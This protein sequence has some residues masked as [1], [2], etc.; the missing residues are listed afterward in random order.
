MKHWLPGL[1]PQRI[2]VST[3]TKGWY[4][5]ADKS[6]Y[7]L[8][9]VSP[10]ATPETVR[11]AY[12]R[13]SE[14]Y[15]PFNVDGSFNSDLKIRQDAIK[16]AFF[17]LGAPEKRAKYDQDRIEKLGA[18]APIPQTSSSWS[19]TSLLLVLFVLGASGWFYYQHQKAE[20][21]IAQERAIAAAKAR[22]IAETERIQAE[23]IRTDSERI[24]AGRQSYR[25][26]IQSPED[27]ARREHEMTLRNY[28]N[29]Q[30]FASQQMEYQVR[31]DA[32]EQRRSEEMR[33]R[34]EQQAETA[35]RAQ[36][37]REKAELC[38]IERERYGTSVSC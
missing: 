38:R 25:E 24:K 13:L 17:I 21:M 8:L 4:A 33:R 36:A 19:S 11:E 5:V 32:N 9:E 28:T 30:R 23:R 35:A 7:D 16:E 22:E 37:A 29:E 20:K 34:E 15:N 1:T 12:E 2:T 27:R 10:K 14:K 31:R 26:I 6:L 3:V 18:L